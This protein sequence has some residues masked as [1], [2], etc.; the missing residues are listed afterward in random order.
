M[1]EIPTLEKRRVQAQVIKPMYE[2]MEHAL[3]AEKAQQILA[4][5]IRKGAVV[6]AVVLVK[7]P[8]FA[9]RA[10]TVPGEV[11]A[12]DRIANCHHA[13]V[14]PVLRFVVSGRSLQV[15]GASAVQ[16]VAAGDRITVVYDPRDPREADIDSV[17][18]PWFWPV[19]WRLLFTLL[20]AGAVVGWRHLLRPFRD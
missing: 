3:G 15:R 7:A 5:A 1:T 8:V 10:T 11:A 19:V 18:H 9:A 17:W 4:N 6:G 14:Y 20:L 2:E 16:D 12:L 13:C